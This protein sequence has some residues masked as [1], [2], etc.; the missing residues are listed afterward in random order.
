MAR[1]ATITPRFTHVVTAEQQ[2]I[3]PKQ[4]FTHVRRAHETARLLGGSLASFDAV[5]LSVQELRRAKKGSYLL[6]A[7]PENLPK[8][9]GWYRVERDSDHNT[10][11]FVPITET[12]AGAIIRAGRAYDVLFVSKRAVNAAKEKRPVGLAVSYDYGDQ[13][14]LYA[15]A[16][17]GGD[18][19]AAITSSSAANSIT[20]EVGGME[21]PGAYSASR[22]VDEVDLVGLQRAVKEIMRNNEDSAQTA[23]VTVTIKRISN[24][25]RVVL[26]VR[27]I[28]LPDIPT[29]G[30]E[31]VISDERKQTVARVWGELYR[32]FFQQP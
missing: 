17:L 2:A 29:V 19:R 11:T 18:A 26:S 22:F 14:Y 9:T 15:D 8:K 7:D 3:V 24:S 21:L 31:P 30:D 32:G 28:D 20:D 5:T 6:A 10:V 12:E 23:R 13:W 4:A 25:P 1:Q 27:D 16:W